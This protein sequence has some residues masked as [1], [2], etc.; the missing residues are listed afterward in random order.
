MNRAEQL[1]VLVVLPLACL[2]LPAC[3]Q[4]MQDQPRYEPLERS[5]FFDDQRAARPLLPGTIARGHLDEDDAL[6][7]GQAGNAP[8]E[9]I[10]MPIEPAILAR[11]RERYDIYCSPCHDRVGTGAGMIVQRGLKRPPSFHEERL[12]IAPAGH[13]FQVISNGFGVMSSYAAQ[14]PARDRWAIVAYIRALQLSQHAQLADVPAAERQ[15]LE[16][17]RDQSR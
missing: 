5:D 4:D 1:R 11:G 16:K 6:F 15:R 17:E 3:R 10:P 2:L 8:L 9:N 7:R 14:I 12:R 13:F